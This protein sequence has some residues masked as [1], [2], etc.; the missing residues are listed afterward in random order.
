MKRDT[1]KH[2]MECPC[3]HCQTNG[4]GLF[5]TLEVLRRHKARRITDRISG[6]ILALISRRGSVEGGR[7]AA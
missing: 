3:G 5:A 2:W 1:S 6:E 4:T 7:N